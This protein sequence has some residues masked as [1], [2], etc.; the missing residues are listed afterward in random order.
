MSVTYAL[1]GSV[2]EITIDDGKAN[3]YTYELLEELGAAL[4]RAETEAHA[5][6]LIGRPGRFSAGFALPVMTESDE[7]AQ[8]LVAAGGRAVM[9]LFMFP[10]PV[11]AACTGHALAAGGIMLLACD[12]RI[13]ADGAFKIGLNEVA[14][15][16]HLP[17][18]AVELARYH[19]PPSLFDAIVLGEVGDPQWALEHRFIDRVVAPDALLDVA[20]S[21]AQTLSALRSDAVAK[22]KRAARQ[23]IADHVAVTFDADIAT[24]T[25]PIV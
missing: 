12:R 23:R 16:M 21:E 20:R 8:G 11:V 10:M 2:A 1:N 7:S 14:I 13:G 25:S 22:T 5:V 18:Y 24:I 9:R 19:M 6:L 3:A 17:I 4:D 15:G